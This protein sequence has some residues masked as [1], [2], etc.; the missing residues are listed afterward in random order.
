[1]S[2]YNPKEI[3]SKWQAR[4]EEAGVYQTDM[5]SNDGQK[6]YYNLT[7]YPYPSGNL[8]TGHWYAYT[9]PDIFG[10]YKRMRGYNVFF[11]FGYDAFGLPAENAAIKRNI[12][13]AIWTR[14]NIEYMTN[15]VQNPE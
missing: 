4:W 2:T 8:H 7:M 14:S 3:E 1:M 11:P 13:P 12:H 5:A 10:R 6:N 9:G 15:Q